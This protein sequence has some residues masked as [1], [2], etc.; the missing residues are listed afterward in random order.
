M[1][2][3]DHLAMLWFFLLILDE[4]KCHAYDDIKK[5]GKVITFFSHHDY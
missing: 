1:S 2:R 4:G 5:N 3:A